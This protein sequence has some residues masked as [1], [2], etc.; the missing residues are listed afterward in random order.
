MNRR[1]SL[2]AIGLGTISTSLLLEACHTDTKAPVAAEVPAADNTGREA[3]EIEREKKLKSE[4]FFSKQEMLT[5]TVLSDL[6]IPADETSISASKAGVPEFIEYIVKDIPAHK[7]PMRGGLKWLDLQCLNR[8]DHVFTDCSTQQQ[9]DL[10]DEIAYPKKS[11]T[12]NEGR[13]CIL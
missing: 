5:I 7:I 2:K 8:Y 3:H 1:Q 13:R 10:L 9:T 6:I 4:T 11:Q 12:G